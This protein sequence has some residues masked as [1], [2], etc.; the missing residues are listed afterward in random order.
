MG[1]VWDR[2]SALP[3]GKASRTSW[4]GSLVERALALLAADFRRPAGPFMLAAVLSVGAVLEG[5]RAAQPVVPPELAIILGIL[6]TAP[7]AAI[8][9][10][11]GPAIG[12]VLAASAVFV[13]VGR[14]SWSV[15]AMIG[16]L[17]ALA[18]CPV[19]LPRRRAVQAVA[20]TEVAVLLALLGLAGSDTPWDATA[21][22]ALAVIAAWGRGR[23][24][25]PGGSRRSS[26]PLP[27]SRSGT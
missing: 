1:A 24:C 11:P 6:A 22:E 19:L 3:D 23:C 15:A 27:P 4:P 25:G 14:L 26:R 21:A 20:A 8:R 16:W 7:I 18:A 17:V 12:V 13:V 2:L 9:R 5:G 10:F